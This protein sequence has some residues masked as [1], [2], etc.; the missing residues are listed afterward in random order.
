MGTVKCMHRRQIQPLT[1][2]AD[3]VL[4]TIEPVL[5]LMDAEATQYAMAEFTFVRI[6]LINKQSDV[7]IAR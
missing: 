1:G 3:S 5:R 7:L 4:H 2:A 6:D